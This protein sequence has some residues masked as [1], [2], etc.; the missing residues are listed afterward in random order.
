MDAIKTIVVNNGGNVLN[1]TNL[2]NQTVGSA[3]FMTA[4]VNALAQGQMNAN[5]NGQTVDFAQLVAANAENGGQE[6]DVLQMLAQ[7]GTMP[8]LLTVNQLP[9]MM[10]GIEMPKVL[11]G[12]EMPQI[13]T[14]N[15][16]PKVTVDTNLPESIE[17][18]PEMTKPDSLS[19]I[20][21]HTLKLEAEQVKNAPETVVAQTTGNQ[22]PSTRN[23]YREIS[24]VETLK[25][26]GDTTPTLKTYDAKTPLAGNA[27]NNELSAEIAK[28]LIM[29]GNAKDFS[30][31]YLSLISQSENAADLQTL[32]SSVGTLNGSVSQSLGLINAMEK[33]G[34]TQF[35]G[36]SEDGE[37]KG[38]LT[39]EQLV[40]LSALADN[41]SSKNGSGSSLV[42]L[43]LDENFGGMGNLDSLGVTALLGGFGNYSAENLVSM[44]SGTG[45][46]NSVLSAFSDN[47][48]N[49]SSLLGLG[50][51]SSTNLISQIFSGKDNKDETAI[52]M[53]TIIPLDALKQLANVKQKEDISKLEKLAEAFEKGDATVSKTTQYVMAD[54]SVN[55]G[56]VTNQ[57]VGVEYA[58]QMTQETFDS[59]VSSQ[60]DFSE[61]DILIGENNFA[62]AVREAKK[63][64]MR[65]TKTDK[66]QN[67][68]QYAD[69]EAQTVDSQ[70]R[71]SQFT[72]IV[73]ENVTASNVRQQTVEQIS[74]KLT[75]KYEEVETF[76]VKL[77]PEG[78]GEVT[79]N[80]EKTDDGIILELVASE[81]STAQMLDKEMNELQS[82]LSQFNA[83]VNEIRVAEPVQAQNQTNDG[84]LQQDF[85]EQFEQNQGNFREGTPRYVRA[86]N[87][88]SEQSADISEPVYRD[89][90]K[91]NTFI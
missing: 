76:S 85:S 7:N 3:D 66:N 28:N 89:N 67:L 15:E 42:D 25:T 35:V 54:N 26:N 22:S 46:L 41:S 83:Q 90:S 55:K 36:L 39:A 14:G 71:I 27:G 68:P 48:D 81:K 69:V 45:G 50:G 31:G 86:R 34:I 62:N 38:T 78:L 12:N 24:A 75:Q 56:N 30:A 63:N 10:T 18:L 59:D 2:V 21:A 72:R 4:F 60:K 43:L 57:Q 49:N 8:E 16:N 40:M 87:T 29:T 80:L 79:V 70:E 82:A 17:V 88:I 44:M 11:S 23:S 6:A 84:F 74:A 58:P 52:P 73:R 64:V 61:A 33:L 9:E 37:A 13:H 91:I 47:D 53:S 20:K 1:Q 5:Q 19:Q 65:E 32:L 77:N 51:L